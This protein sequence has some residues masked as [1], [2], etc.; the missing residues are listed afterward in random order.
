MPP[1]GSS[2]SEDWRSPSWGRRSMEG[3][4]HSS[5]SMVGEASCQTRAESHALADKAVAQEEVAARWPHSWSLL[6]VG[7]SLVNE[8]G[9]TLQAQAGIYGPRTT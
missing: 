1:T 5:C 7:G 4:T 9:W 3:L 8:K 2:P 6:L